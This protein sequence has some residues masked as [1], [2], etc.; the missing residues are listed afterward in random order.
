MIGACMVS[1]KRAAEQK[2]GIFALP[3]HVC[4]EE[5]WSKIARYPP[6]PIDNR[7][8]CCRRPPAPIA[9]IPGQMPRSKPALVHRL[10]R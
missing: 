8:G 5:V 3:A 10:Q 6:H 1:L 9:A 4:R 2:M 7:S